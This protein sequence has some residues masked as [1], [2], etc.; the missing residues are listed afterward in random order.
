MEWTR[1]P[2]AAAAAAAA[3]TRSGKG[4]SGTA[5][6]ARGAGGRS[7]KADARHNKH[8]RHHKGAAAAPPPDEASLAARARTGE[9]LKTAAE[10]LFRWRAEVT[11]QLQLE[12]HADVLTL[13]PSVQ[14]WLRQLGIDGAESGLLRLFAGAGEG[15][16]AALTGLR[17]R[18]MRLVATLRRI[19]CWLETVGISIARDTVWVGEETAER[20]AAAH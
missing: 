10:S 12:E 5:A 13:R 18:L 8:D 7:W 4:A 6:A 9:W 1:P 16:M 11:G 14:L 2:A 17:S 15:D 19:G 20:A 3:A